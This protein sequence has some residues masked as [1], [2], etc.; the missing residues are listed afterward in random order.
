MLTLKRGLKTL[1]IALM[2]AGT[3]LVLGAGVF[4]FRVPLADLLDLSTGSVAATLVIVAFLVTTLIAAAAYFVWRQGRQAM[5]TVDCLTSETLRLSRGDYNELNTNPRNDELGDLAVAVEGLRVNLLR[6]SLTRQFLE[7]IL[8]SI[9]DAVIVTSPAGIIERVNN[10]AYELADYNRRDLLGKSVATVLREGLPELLATEGTV[11]NIRDSVLY[12]RY[13][14]KVPVSLSRSLMYTNGGEIEC[15][16][17]VARDITERKKAEKRI[18]FLARYDPLTKI[19]NRMQF[20]HQ[21]QQAI[22]RARRAHKSL[23]LLYLD[24]DRF[25]EVNDS[26]G[27]LIGDRTLELAVR[28]VLDALPP[29]TVMGRLSG[30]E[31]AVILEG[32]ALDYDIKTSVNDTARVLLDSIARTFYPQNQ[33]V[34]LTASVGIAMF[35]DDGDNVIDLIRNADAAMYLA[36]R[37]AGNTIAFYSPDINTRKVDRLIL[38][39]KLQ[40]ALQR[41]ELSVRYQ[42]KIDLR[43]GNIVGAEALLRWHCR[44]QGDIAPSQFIPLAEESNLINEIGEWVLEEVC[45]DYSNWQKKVEA[46][47]RVAVNLSLR[48]LKQPNLISRVGA[49]FDKYHV[50]PSSLELEITESTLMENPSRT[51]KTLNELFRMGFHLSIDDFGTGYSSLSALQNFPIST[52]KI[53]Q[54]FVKDSAK[55]DDD[56]TIVSTIIEMGR[57]LQ[58]DVVAEGVETEEQ[59]AFLRKNNCTFAQGHLF[60][61]PVSAADYLELLVAQ[62]GGTGRHLQ[63]FA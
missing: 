33:E 14:E 17:F 49:I 38:R 11:R 4:L 18:R 28:R 31:F 3:G 52:L 48:Q 39:T 1:A 47:G 2:A 53:D 25:K 19:P 42:P 22:A 21:L 44:D 16:V 59:L 24:L 54:S 57:T 61:R 50:S 7:K 51:V 8:A 37:S 30:D 56:A 32:P 9:N 12:T 35:P 46:P 34:F 20:Q 55:D 40:R 13:G 29:G 36:K 62:S 43:S 63:L 10:A 45:S 23:A 60:C 15:F 26:Y 27:H 41:K 6:S 5:D 58:M